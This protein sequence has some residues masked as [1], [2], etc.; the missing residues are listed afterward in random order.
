M[1]VSGDGTVL[2]REMANAIS[3]GKR[4]ALGLGPNAAIGAI[5]N[6]WGGAL[7]CGYAH[8]LKLTALEYAIRGD[9]RGRP[10]CIVRW[11]DQHG[12]EHF[13]GVPKTS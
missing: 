12:R 10:I 5:S 13:T 7:P 2:C 9:D 11:S 4:L 8:G 1:E 3:F 6:A